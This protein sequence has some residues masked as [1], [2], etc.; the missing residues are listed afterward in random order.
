MP[1]VALVIIDMQ[2]DVVEPD[3]FGTVLGNQVKPPQ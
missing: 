3:G 1:R 2:R